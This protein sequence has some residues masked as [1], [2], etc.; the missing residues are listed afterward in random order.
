VRSNQG[1]P[2]VDGQSFEAIEAEEGKE[3]FLQ[4]LRE[5]L[6]SKTYRADA[7]RRVWIPKPDGSNR[8]LGIPTIRDRVVQMAA[9]LVMEPI[10]EADFCEHS[11]GFRPKRSAHDAVDVVA[12]ALLAGH[13][14]VIDAD[15]SKYFDTIAHAK[16]LAVVAERIS[17]GAI[18]ALIKQWLK[19]AVVEED[20][21]G[22]RRTG[23]GGKGNRQGTREARGNFPVAGEPVSA[24]VGSDMGAP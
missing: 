4:R 10:F 7:V 22:T 5:Q 18:L 14:Q 2:G 21:D 19:A 23:G 20:E 1:A 9:K 8:P 16:L 11:Y 3:R 17:D 13:G 24:P 15:L 12:E 6:E